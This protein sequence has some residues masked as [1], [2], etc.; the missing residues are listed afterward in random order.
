MGVLSNAGDH[1]RARALLQRMRNSSAPP[2]LITYG[3][4]TD[5][6]VRGGVP[7][8]EV[9]QLFDEMQVRFSRGC[10]F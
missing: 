6:C 8:G 5:A 2:D 1:Q 10:F 4:V 3:K 9:L 7:L